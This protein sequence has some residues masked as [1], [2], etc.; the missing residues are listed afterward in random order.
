[1]IPTRAQVLEAVRAHVGDTEVAGGQAAHD[2]A[3]SEH[4]GA[5]YRALVGRLVQADA[6]R[7]RRTS[8]YVLPAWT[9]RLWPAT[10]GITG[11]GML[12]VLWERTTGTTYTVTGVT[13][14]TGYVD[15]AVTSHTLATGDRVVTWGIGGL[16]ADIHDQWT[17]TVPGSTLIRLNG[18]VATGTWTSGGSVASAAEDWPRD[19]MASLSTIPDTGPLSTL[20]YYV[21]QDGRFEFPPCSVARQLRI[22]YLLSGDCPSDPSASMQIDD[23]LDFLSHYTAG[24][25]LA[26]KGGTGAGAEWFTMACGNPVGVTTGR[27]GGFLEQLIIPAVRSMQH[28]RFRAQPFRPKRNTG[29]STGGARW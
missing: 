15:L 16:S 20:S 26:S 19:P 4:L 12:E 2:A 9:S 29:P 3:L 23:S 7:V 10:A 22:T 14:G 5:A 8:Y 18:C 13:L 21:F 6:R 24:H 25:F 11:L 17:I 27:I 1:M 28:M